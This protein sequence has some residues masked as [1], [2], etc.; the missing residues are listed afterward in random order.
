MTYV[1]PCARPENDPDD[2]FI[3]RDGRQ[4]PDD[5]MTLRDQKAAQTRRRHA[6]DKCH[7][8]CYARLSCL[9]VAL[10]DA[11]PTPGKLDIEHGIRGG[12]YP[13]ELRQIERVRQERLA[14]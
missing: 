1:P 4:Y 11:G 2:W 8:E 10:G 14:E 9:A 3:E 7:V 12:Y 5:Q 13:E 6:R